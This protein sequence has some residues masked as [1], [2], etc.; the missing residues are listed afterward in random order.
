MSKRRTDTVRKGHHHSHLHM[1]RNQSYNRKANHVNSNLGQ[2]KMH[3][4]ISFFM[5]LLLCCAVLQAQTF[6][7]SIQGT[8]TDSTGAAVPG[9]E[10]TVANPETGLTRTSA[11]N[12]AGELPVSQLPLGTFEGTTQKPR[13]RIL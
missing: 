13:F 12:D 5:F 9:A 2:P 7:G 11:T 10:V 6:R 4:R 3:T 8:V 1:H